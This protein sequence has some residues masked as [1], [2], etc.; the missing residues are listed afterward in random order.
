MGEIFARQARAAGC[1]SACYARPMDLM[2]VAGEASADLHGARLLSELR[3][4]RPD[5]QA[6]GCGGEGLADAGCEL[7]LHASQLAHIGL[8]EVVR[9]LPRIYAHYRLLVNAMRQR[10]PKALLLIDLP[11]FNLRLA[12]KAAAL[13]IPVIYFI[14]P[15]LWAWRPGRVELIRKF[16]TRMICILP[17]EQAFYKRFGLEVDYVGHP[18]VDIVRPV[19]PRAEFLAEQHLDPAVPL[20]TLL[21]GSRRRELEYHLEPMLEAVRLIRERREAQFLLPVAS[22]L[23]VRQV[24][25]RIPAEMRGYLKVIAGQVY[26]AVFHARAAI[27]CSGT[28]TLETALLGTPMVV[29]YRLSELTWR[30]GRRWVKTPHYAMVNLIAEKRLV[31]EL[32]QQDCEAANI[33]RHLEPLID[34]TPQREQMLRG[35]YDVRRRLGSSGAIRRAAIIV[36]EILGGV[37]RRVPA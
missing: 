26:D 8:F 5:L 10:R 23:D 24:A 19:R 16:V 11:D 20:I 13:G 34:E 14:S 17:F 6:F 9:S 35:Y 1:G 36:E 2:I 15:Q 4:R 30:V 25:E 7:I 28:A 29:I 32:I 22:T 33:V 27:V 31:P 21:P 12:R 3:R 18:L 37:P